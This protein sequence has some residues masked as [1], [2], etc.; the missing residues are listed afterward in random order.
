MGQ[1]RHLSNS[2]LPTQSSHSSASV[3]QPAT[4]SSQA[5]PEAATQP[6]PSLAARAATLK[7]LVKKNR[8][9]TVKPMQLGVSKSS[10]VP[11]K[12]APVQST[13]SSHD[14]ALYKTA[15]KE[16]VDLVAEIEAAMQGDAKGRGT[17]LGTVSAKG[18]RQPAKAQGTSPALQLGP[19]Q[20]VHPGGAQQTKIAQDKD[21]VPKTTARPEHNK[22]ST[23]R[24]PSPDRR[25]KQ[26]NGLE[27][28]TT[29]ASPAVHRLDG[30]SSKAGNGESKSD[31]FYT[32][33]QDEHAVQDT[34]PPG[35]GQGASLSQN[36]HNK[37][38][39][40]KATE[41]KG[42]A[43]L[44]S[45][46]ATEKAHDT[47]PGMPG[48]ESLPF[49]PPRLADA[50]HKPAPL[51]AEMVSIT[52]PST[53]SS[54]EQQ[55]VMMWL[56]RS[57]YYNEAARIPIVDRWHKLAEVETLKAKLL[58]EDQNSGFDFRPRTS[59]QPDNAAPD[60]TPMDIDPPNPGPSVHESLPKRVIAHAER[61]TT[62]V[63]TRYRD[64]G[65]EDRELER[66]WDQGYLLGERRFERRRDRDD[67]SVSPRRSRTLTP[68][69][70]W[71]S[72]RNYDGSRSPP[73]RRYRHDLLWDRDWD[74]AWDRDG[75]RGHRPRRSQSPTARGPRPQTGAHSRYASGS[76]TPGKRNS[77][78]SRPAQKANQKVDLGRPGETRF[79][80]IKSFNEANIYTS[81]KEGLWT[82]QPQNVKPLTEAYTKSKNVLLF[83][84]V[85]DSGAFQGYARMCGT[86][87]TA[88][89]QPNWIGI[90][91]RRTSP[92]FRVE[93]LNTT[94]IVFKHAKHLRNPLNK[95]LSVQIGKD[96]QEVAESTGA[97]LVDLMETPV[98]ERKAI[99]VEP[100]A[101]AA[102]W[103]KAKRGQEDAP[104]RSLVSRITRS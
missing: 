64:Y 52:I 67:R 83:F 17:A 60:I 1:G 9:K 18:K 94:P 42:G 39:S 12:P 68:G 32:H 23:I 98:C 85:N 82:T 20:S 57:G 93:W 19:E 91:E 51:K 5:P 48:A 28:A 92:P 79:F 63:N 4:I 101:F 14:Q 47:Y 34:E 50:T 100:A 30:S 78:P 10:S 54:S 35:E 33:N 29:I 96:G 84:S 97:A 56:E 24:R 70:G 15:E 40:A 26:G 16:I 86:P 13:R 72:H 43:R 31:D 59:T 61:K 65:V 80:A 71:P 103:D 69:T 102:N 95:N 8:Q 41:G 25:Q 104:I 45:D 88:I 90:N 66:R 27:D 75:Y 73:P 49:E 6:A 2:S 53:G 81:I 77:S 38:L 11:P 36:H 21:Q 55:D 37:S 58:R 89:D 62:P 74:R 87:D 76:R 99:W 46:D 22:N 3:A 44:R 7:E